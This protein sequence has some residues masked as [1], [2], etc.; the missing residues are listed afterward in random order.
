MA[1]VAIVVARAVAVVVP[2]AASSEGASCGA[3]YAIA[4]ATA[5]TA[6]V[7]RT[8]PMIASYARETR[9]TL[10][11]ADIGTNSAPKNSA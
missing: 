1:V 5:T 2:S 11:T 3:K 6:I 7:F 4:T 10:S 8:L 9:Q